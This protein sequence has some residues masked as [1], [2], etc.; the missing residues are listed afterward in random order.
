MGLEA[1]VQL[2]VKQAIEELLTSRDQRDSSIIQDASINYDQLVTLREQL[3]RT[4][5]ELHEAVEAKERATQQFYDLRRELDSEVAEK[6][7]L[8]LENRS[9]M[10]KLKQVEAAR[11]SE[12]HEPSDASLKDRHANKLQMRIEQLQDDLFKL[13]NSKEEY[14]VKNDLLE[15]ELMELKLRNEELQR[16]ANEA[17]RLK[18]DLD[19]MREATEKAEKQE[20][21][22]NSGFCM[23]AETSKRFSVAA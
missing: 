15:S 10:N 5:D 18:D 23:W 16:K 7:Q 2:A 8:Q 4:T 17:R 11:A 14:R 12:Q 9:L 21:T 13:E 22:V 20:A 1:E 6:E 19:I 3:K